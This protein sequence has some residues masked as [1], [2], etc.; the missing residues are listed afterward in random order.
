[1]KLIVCEDYKEL[2]KKAAEIVAEQIEK[3]PDSVLGLATGSTPVG[4]Y[5]ELS[6]MNKK[7]IIDFEK[8]VSYNLDEYYPIDDSNPQ[9]Y[10]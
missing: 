7:G 4:M 6:E 9:S 5:Q 1:M 3:K 10:H 2:S 8:V